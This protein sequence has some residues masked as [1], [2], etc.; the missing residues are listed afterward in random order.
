[1]KIKSKISSII[2][3]ASL[4]AGIISPTFNSIATTTSDTYSF[5]ATENHQASG[6][7]TFEFCDECF[8]RSSFLGCSHLEILSAQAAN[9]SY[10][11]FGDNYTDTSHYP[12]NIT[13]MLKKCGFSDVSTNKYYTSMSSE[14][15]AAVAVGHMTVTQDGKQYTL[16]AVIPR[17]ARYKQEWAGNFNVGDSGIHEGFKAGRDEILR[18]LKKYIKE[19]NISGDLKVWTAAHS[20]G[21]ALANQLGAFLAGGGIVYFG[22]SVSITPQDVYCYT[23]GT[24]R[25]IINGTD[26]NTE[27]SVAGSRNAPAY[28]NDTP[29]EAYTYSGGGTVDIHDKAYGGIRN[30]LSSNDTITHLP[31]SAWGFERYGTDI[32]CERDVPAD[33]ML[34]ELRNISKFTSDYF[35]SGKGADSFERKTF[36]L[37]TL[38]L[39]PDEKEHSA[40]DTESFISQMMTGLSKSANSK[41]VY[42][43]EGYQETLISLG[44]LLGSLEDMDLLSVS[45]GN[46]D[47]FKPLIPTYLAYASERLQAE[48]KAENEAEAASIAIGEIAEYATGEEIDPDTVT[49]DDYL[50]LFAKY[51]TENENSP[52][53]E[54]LYKMIEMSVPEEQKAMLPLLLGFFIK[55]YSFGDELDITEGAKALMKACVDGPEE[56]TAAKDAYED[57]KT[58]R[59][60]L[61]TIIVVA[62]PDLNP[63]LIDDESHDFKGDTPVSEVMPALLSAFMVEKDDDGN[64]IK[65]YSSFAESAD[66]DLIVMLDEVVQRFI[67]DAREKYGEEYAAATENYLNNLKTN[68]SKA[69]TLMTYTLFYTGDEFNS[70]E[71]IENL[72]TFAGNIESFAL[73]HFNEV[74]ISYAKAAKLYDSGYTGHSLAS[75]TGNSTVT[76]TNT[77]TSTS[78]TTTTTASKSNSASSASPSTGDTGSAIPLTVVAIAF[79]T[80]FLMRKRNNE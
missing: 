20:R 55:D 21:G 67:N 32:E 27:L 57:A 44:G 5:T 35:D 36:D 42:I 74:Y 9:A 56:G 18:Y 30:L 48:G 43:D 3:A 52:F 64:V 73:H 15:S 70:A 72:A 37:K 45:E 26:K 75:P 1:M 14:N 65:R 24:P 33:K 19:K 10:S 69:R 17:S 46:F 68:I 80:A 40:M 79:V 50:L 23:F 58:V 2:I 16:L 49:I 11:K 63:I 22:D 31:L 59:S 66:A 61:G 76:T 47:Y 53:A 39:V 71:N 12:D 54:Q 6:T 51:I 34:E 25:T 8:T 38:T 29:G 4:T 78:K 60:V 28:S 41:E 13:D 62:Y 7:D 77:S